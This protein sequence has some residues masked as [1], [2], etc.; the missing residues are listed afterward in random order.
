MGSQ[1]VPLIRIKLQLAAVD[2]IRSER[3]PKAV[4]TGFRGEQAFK[5]VANRIADPASISFRKTVKNHLLDMNLHRWPAHRRSLIEHR[6]SR[7]E[8]G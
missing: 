7:I 8:G 3:V 5:L 4:E 2:A 6:R 1:G